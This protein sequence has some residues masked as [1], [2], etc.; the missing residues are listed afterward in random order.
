MLSKQIPKIEKQ[1]SQFVVNN[2]KKDVI[3]V[4]KA[5]DKYRETERDKETIFNI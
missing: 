1:K 5:K 2:R 3:N 4:M